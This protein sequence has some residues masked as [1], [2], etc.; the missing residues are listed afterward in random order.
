L[1]LKAALAQG[2]DSTLTHRQKA[3]KEAAARDYQRRVDEALGALERE[4]AK[5]STSG[6]RP[7]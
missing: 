7:G 6:S 3:A 5:K 1:H 2:N 4:R